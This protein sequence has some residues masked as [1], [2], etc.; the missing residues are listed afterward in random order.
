MVDAFNTDVIRQTENKLEMLSSKVI[1]PEKHGVKL[2][3]GVI[4]CTDDNYEVR[5]VTKEKAMKTL[6][7]MNRNYSNWQHYMSGSQDEA[8]PHL[9]GPGGDSLI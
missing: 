8:S 1:K 6:N 4:S 3:K 5:E 2:E 9:M 7:D